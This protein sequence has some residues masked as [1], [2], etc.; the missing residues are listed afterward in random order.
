MRRVCLTTE[1]KLIEMQSGGKVDRLPRDHGIFNDAYV[2]GKNLALS[3]GKTEQ[4]AEA[5]GNIAAEAAYLLYINECDAL[6]AMRLNTLKQNAINNGH[7]ESDI[8]VKWVTDEEWAVIQEA[9]KPVPT[10]AELR[11]AEYPPI[12]D[13]LDEILR[14]LDESGM[15]LTPGL[16]QTITDWKQVKVD[17]P[18]A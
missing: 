5:V 2:K 4:E 8:E 3:E 17:I 15:V 13:Q 16:A 14:F 6:E 11:R 7:L 9:N 1:G 18:K 10:Y 12:G